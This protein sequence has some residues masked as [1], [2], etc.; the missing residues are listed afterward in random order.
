M[1]NDHRG[2]IFKLSSRQKYLLNENLKKS[3][4]NGYL[5]SRNLSEGKKPNPSTN[6]PLLSLRKPEQ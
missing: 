4:K 3:V 1:K 2:N 6:I 5:K